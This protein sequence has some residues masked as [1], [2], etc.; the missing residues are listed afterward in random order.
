MLTLNAAGMSNVN[1][2][3]VLQNATIGSSHRLLFVP[4]LLPLRY[5]GSRSLGSTRVI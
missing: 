1:A 3:L 4:L 2:P 5:Y